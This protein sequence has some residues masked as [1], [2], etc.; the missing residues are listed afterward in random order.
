L[1]GHSPREQREENR[2]MRLSPWILALMTALSVSAPRGLPAGESPDVPR[3]PGLYV[4][5]RGA[6]APV[7]EEY[8]YAPHCGAVVEI[9][10]VEA[11]P[12]EARADE[13]LILRE[14]V[15]DW[16]APVRADVER[17]PGRDDAVRISPPPLEPGSYLI[18]CRPRW[19]RPRAF[20]VDAAA[21]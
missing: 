15:D 14:S 21:R 18:R 6:I 11:G 12:V 2:T 5:S 16:P 1:R 17:V 3:A 13:W 4:K 10:A 8:A 20:W 19:R 9:F 7:P